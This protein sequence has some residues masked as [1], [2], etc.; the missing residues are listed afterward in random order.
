MQKM[1]KRYFVAR[2]MLALTLCW[3]TATSAAQNVSGRIT[4]EGKGIAGV[5]VSD[6]YVVTQ[7]D[8]NGNYN[9][10]SGKK[11]GYVFYTLPRGYEPQV[12]DGFNPMF[13][14]KLNT[15]VSAKEQHDFSLNKVDNDRYSLVISA[16]YHLANRNNDDAQF[17]ATFLKRMQQLKAASHY[18]VYNTILGDL[19]WDVY[20]YANNY[21]LKDFVNTMKTCKFPLITFPVIGNHDNNPGTPEGPDTDFEAS[22]PWRTIMCPNY[23][24]YNLGKIHYV[25]L[26]NII[27]Q[28]KKGKGP[29]KKGVVGER[30]YK[31]EITGEQLE[32]LKKDLAFVDTNTTVVVEFHSPTWVL[33][34]NTFETKG[35]N[36]SAKE[37]SDIMKPYKRVHYVSG[38][39]HY[40]QN[41]H[42]KEYPNITEHNI[43]AVCAMWWWTGKLSDISV[44]SDGTPGGYSLWNVNGDSITWKYMSNEDNNGIQMRVYDINAVKEY[45]S[46]EATLQ[47]FLSK[48]DKRDDFKNWSENSILINVFAY[49]TD[50]KVEAFEGKKL[51]AV[52]RMPACEDPMPAIAHDLSRYKNNKNFARNDGS[53][54]NNHIFFAQCTTSDKPVTVKVTDSFGNIYTKKVARPAAFGLSM[55]REQIQK[56]KISKRYKKVLR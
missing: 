38:H 45:Y 43:A 42:P 46:G 21:N 34:K 28:N 53:S 16:D 18:P 35:K 25:V 36:K 55:D 32:W 2:I 31:C 12:K 41:M 47:K 4:C 40:M 29:Y 48:N 20:W 52:K 33:D 56:T 3:L 49:D 1:T 54:K 50:W 8:E 44:C 9:I 26:D 11:N 24:S 17:K 22:M 13:W 10:N 5:T 51:L 15:D 27:Y 30:N 6:G 14:A 39:T 19:S 7:T 23:Y 37:L